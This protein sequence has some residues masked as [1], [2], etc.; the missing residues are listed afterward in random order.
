[1]RALAVI[2]ALM[3]VPAM[4][5]VTIFAASSLKTVLDQIAAEW[6]GEPLV[7]SYGGSAALAKQIAAGAPADIFISASEEW[8]DD[9]ASKALIQPATRHDIAGNKLILIAH[10]AW[11]PVKI[12]A[13]MDLVGLLKDGKLSMAFVD[14]VPAGQY[15]KAALESLGLWASVE[16]MVVQSENVRAALALVTSGEA[17]L[18]VVYASDAVAEPGV[19]VLGT[20]PGDSHPAIT[21]PA[22]LT[23]TASPAAQ[24]V[25]D[26]LTDA[27]A[28]AIFAAQ[29]F[30]PPP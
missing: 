20:F 23:M 17:A 26:H 5:D 3:P 13:G 16:P 4:A 6:K 12:A 10:D 19:T 18:G 29:G 15:G 30:L 25:L 14:S 2:L 22:A 21:Y 24:A 8:M 28:Q 27:D 1:M 9:L 7:L 11:P